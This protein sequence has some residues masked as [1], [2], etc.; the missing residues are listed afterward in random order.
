MNAQLSQTLPAIGFPLDSAIGTVEF[1]HAIA[2]VLGLTISFELGEVGALAMA[3]DGAVHDLGDGG[4]APVIEQY[5]QE[6][7]GQPLCNKALQQARGSEQQLFTIAL[8]AHH[9]LTIKRTPCAL[10]FVAGDSEIA[11]ADDRGLLESMACALDFLRVARVELKLAH[12]AISLDELHA[13]DAAAGLKDELLDGGGFVHG[14]KG[15]WARA[16]GD[17]DC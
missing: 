6:G 4:L 9:A 7:P 3:F 16:L 12:S 5:R 17:Y 1:A 13:D 8:D 15:R 11:A 10:T 2:R 14:R